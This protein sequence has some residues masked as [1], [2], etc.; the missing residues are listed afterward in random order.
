M[1]AAMR[2][3][4]TEGGK[5]HLHH[6][7]RAEIANEQHCVIESKDVGHDEGR[8]GQTGGV[9]GR[10]HRRRFG[11]GGAGIGGQGHGRGDV[12]HNAEVEHEEVGSH[13]IHAHALH[14]DRGHKWW[15]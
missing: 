8:D 3:I 9:E 2:N 5:D 1:P 12:G 7:Q 6:V 14:Q 10:P 13:Q 15:P 4:P 11:D